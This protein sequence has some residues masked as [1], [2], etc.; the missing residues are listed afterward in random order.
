MNELKFENIS[1]KDIAPDPNQPRKFYDESSM[2]ELCDSIKSCGVIEPIIVRKKSKGKGFLLVCGERRFRASKMAE[3]ES[4]PCII[5]ELNDD[6]ALQMQIIENLHRKDVHPMEEAVA[7]KSFIEGKNWSNDE[8]AKRVGKSDY[9]VRQ[10]L[11]LNS[12]IKPFQELFYHHK[13]TNATALRI[14]AI[15]ADSQQAIFNDRIDEDDLNDKNFIFEFHKYQVNSY[16]GQL[17]EAAFDIKDAS[18]LSSAGACTTCQFNSSVMNLFPDDDKT[19]KCTNIKCFEEKTKIHY[20]RELESAKEDPTV[21]FINNQYYA[22]PTEL[23]LAKSAGVDFLAS[24]DLF[25]V[26]EKPVPPCYEDFVENLEDGD[27]DSEE[28][29]KDQFQTEM[30]EYHIEM[31]KYEKDIQSGKYKKAFVLSGS[32]KGTYVY[33]ELSKKAKATAAAEVK[34]DGQEAPET[35]LAD[36]ND[37]IERLKTKELRSVEIDQNKMWE[38]IKRKFDA[39]ELTKDT[40]GELTALEMSA[41]AKTIYN[42]LT[43]DQ[44]GFLQRFGLKGKSRSG[45]AKSAHRGEAEFE[46]LTAEDMNQMLRFFMISDLPPHVLYTGFNSDAQLAVKVAEQYFP[47]TLQTIQ[48]PYTEKAAKR[49]ATLS[50]RIADLNLQLRNLKTSLKKT[51]SK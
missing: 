22:S 24:A 51:K 39:A 1:L 13:M 33:V 34:E 27:Y 4:I 23:K 41:I 5:R 32:D 50:K 35:T 2:H 25:K 46:N 6:E 30:G 16:T 31:S 44:H 42:N 7:F 10:R 9:Y 38:E 14:A 47:E 40:K 3:N 26:R 43:S 11:K 12:L 19:A 37:E 21:L 29:M 36:I 15:D 17:T 45:G 48:A 49:S 28:E 8:I 18:I 20:S